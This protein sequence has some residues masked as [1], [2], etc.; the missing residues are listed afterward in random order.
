MLQIFICEGFANM[1]RIDF[2]IYSIRLVHYWASLGEGRP[3]I[4]KLY[5]NGFFNNY[6]PCPRYFSWKVLKEVKITLNWSYQC[7]NTSNQ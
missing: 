1:M 5:Q 3:V 6:Y 7:G 2:K 4:L